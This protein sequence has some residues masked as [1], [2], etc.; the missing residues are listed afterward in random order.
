MNVAQLKGLIHKNLVCVHCHAPVELMVS[1]MK[2]L[3]NTLCVCC[4]QSKEGQERHEACMEPSVVKEWHALAFSMYGVNQR[5][6]LG[7]QYTG[8]GY[9]WFSGAKVSLG[10]KPTYHKVEAA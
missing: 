9:M 7:L 8:Q 5:F 4:R 1:I 10:G 2:G 6:L 3:A